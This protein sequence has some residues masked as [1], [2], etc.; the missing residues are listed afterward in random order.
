MSA[1]SNPP[2]GVRYYWRARS[3][4]SYLDGQWT[5]TLT[6]LH[7]ITPDN[8]DLHYPEWSGRRVVTFSFTVRANQ[9]NTPSGPMPTNI[10]RPVQAMIGSADKGS[11][12]LVGLLAKPPLMANEYYRVQSSVSDPTVPQIRASGTDY[13]AWV[14]Q[15]YLQ[16]PVN[17]HRVEGAYTYQFDGPM[18][19]DHVGDRSKYAPNSYGDGYSDVIVGAGSAGCVLAN[20]L[21]ADPAVRVLLLEAGGELTGSFVQAGL[22]DRVAVFVAPK[23]VGGATA[24]TPVAGSGLLLGDAVRLEGL[25]ARPLGDDWLLEGRVAR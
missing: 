5:S 10:T 25:T 18:A 11:V 6:E 24:P 19:Y 14:T 2:Q 3:Y 22:V 1:P 8:F 13:P 4:D 17:R 20:R 7:N 23:L 15:R 12:D 21:S 16:L 9:Q